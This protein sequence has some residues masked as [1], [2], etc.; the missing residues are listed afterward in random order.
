M[1][2]VTVALTPLSR[3]MR[4]VKSRILSSRRW[5]SAMSLYSLPASAGVAMKSERR[6]LQKTRLPAPIIAIFA[7][8]LPR[9]FVDVSGCEVS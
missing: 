6:V 7:I 2:A 1:V 9:F 5:V 8:V 3:T 4:S